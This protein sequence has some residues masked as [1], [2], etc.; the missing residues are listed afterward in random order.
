MNNIYFYLTCLLKKAFLFELHVYT[1]HNENIR[2]NISC[3]MV[4]IILFKFVVNN[5]LASQQ[6]VKMAFQ[7]LGY[8]NFEW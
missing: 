7:F 5:L 3:K 1:R 8:L 2:F 4:E 6:T